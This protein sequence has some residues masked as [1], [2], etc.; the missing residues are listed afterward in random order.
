MHESSQAKMQNSKQ[1][2]PRRTIFQ[3]DQPIESNNQS[4]NHSH[5][6]I[7]LPNYRTPS[8]ATPTSRAR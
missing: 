3:N 6:V 8:W 5:I 1:H 4:I 7:P 2:M